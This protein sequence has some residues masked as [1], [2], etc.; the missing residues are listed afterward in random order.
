LIEVQFAEPAVPRR[1]PL[2]GSR[3]SIG[4]LGPLPRRPLL[5]PPSASTRRARP[6]RGVETPVTSMDSAYQWEGLPAA[7]GP[8]LDSSARSGDS[9]S[10]CR[11]AGHTAVD[12]DAAKDGESSGGR[13]H[14]I[15]E[16]TFISETS[17]STRLQNFWCAML[18][19]SAPRDPPSAGRRQAH[20]DRA[21]GSQRTATTPFGAST[22][23]LQQPY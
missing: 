12:L 9:C 7:Q 6:N 21:G 20:A 8:A 5:P 10:R 19:R 11:S 3:P 18:D 17:P 13:E 16:W 4:P 23:L 15:S 22:R 14:V 2:A 1:G